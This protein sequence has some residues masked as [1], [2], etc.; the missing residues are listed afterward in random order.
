MFL[1][2]LLFTDAC[3]GVCFI[4]FKV[5]PDF[6]LVPEKV[7]YSVEWLYE[8]G[9]YLTGAFSFLRIGGFYPLLCTSEG[10]LLFMWLKILV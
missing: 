4:G 3:L 10:L 6:L 1:I 2:S 5:E 9:V 8:L 7:D